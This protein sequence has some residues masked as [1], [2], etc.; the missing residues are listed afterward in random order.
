M[1]V[2]ACVRACM[3]ACARARDPCVYGCGVSYVCGGACACA[4]VR[5]ATRGAAHWRHRAQTGQLQLRDAG[6]AGQSL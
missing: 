5:C 3:R 2:C 6:D 4:C 1:C